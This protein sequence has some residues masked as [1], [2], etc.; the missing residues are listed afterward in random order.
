VLCYYCVLLVCVFNRLL[1]Q[2]TDRARGIF[3]ATVW[4]GLFARRR[5]FLL[6]EGPRLFYVDAANMVLK[7]E[8]PW[9]V[10]IKCLYA[11]L[12]ITVYVVHCDNWITTTSDLDYQQDDTFQTLASVCTPARWDIPV[13]CNCM[14]TSKMGHSSL[15]QVYVHQQDGKFQSVASVCTPARWDIPVS[16]K[17]MYTSKMGHS[18]MLQVYVHQ[19]DETGVVSFH[20][21]YRVVKSIWTE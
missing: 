15:L 17:C 19:Q 21:N 5:M 16:C 20:I 18:S 6:T 4:Q 3:C 2:T 1:Y 8:V 13:C 9:Y 14:Y 12:L 10:L 7:G 11:L